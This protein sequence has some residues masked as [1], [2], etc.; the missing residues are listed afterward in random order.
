MATVAPS[1]PFVPT[2][3]PVPQIQV[4]EPP[5]EPQADQEALPA[6]SPSELSSE[7][8]Q[9]LAQDV[10]N[11]TQD[12]KRELVEADAR[13]IVSEESSLP[14]YT[15]GTFNH[16]KS[17]VIVAQGMRFIRFPCPSSE[18]EVPIYHA[19]G[20]IAYLSKRETRRSGNAV[21]YSP[22]R[23][24]LISSHYLFGPGR[25]PTLTMLS[26]EDGKNQ[27]V[28]SGKWT[29]RSHNFIYTPAPVSFDWVYRREKVEP[30]LEEPVVRHAPIGASNEKTQA[31]EAAA[32]KKQ[33]PTKQTFL[34]LEVRQKDKK[35]QV[36]RIA[37]LIRN[38]ETRTPGTKSSYAG[39]GGELRI[40]SLAAKAVGIPEELIVATCLM[41]LKKEMDRRRVVQFMIIGAIAM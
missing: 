31:D 2:A 19:N 35:D 11:I 34:S 12:E 40:D 7:S 39:N 27:V 30:A 33:E 22:E 28:V 3:E 13:S 38:E 4:S 5:V 15:P 18:L 36:Q 20:E 29:S 6:Y 32:N 9:Q 8:N 21:L 1:Q 16:S 17:L 23:G 14:A 26:E 41:M 37:Q 25:D 10:A 24:E